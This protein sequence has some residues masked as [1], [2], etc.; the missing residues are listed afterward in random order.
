LSKLSIEKKHILK[1]RLDKI[2]IEK[3][4]KYKEILYYIKIK[5]EYDLNK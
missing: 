5:N 2:N 1:S 4:K 3:Y